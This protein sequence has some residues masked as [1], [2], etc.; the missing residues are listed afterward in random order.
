MPRK[1][2][3]KRGR[4]VRV[5]MTGNSEEE[6]RQRAVEKY[7]NHIIVD[8]KVDPKKRVPRGARIRGYSKY[9]RVYLRER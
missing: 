4:T 6:V 2:Q 8:V 5:F 7:V 9:F 3:I 1:R